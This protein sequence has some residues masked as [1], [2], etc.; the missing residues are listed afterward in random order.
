MATNAVMVRSGTQ[1]QKG[2]F[3]PQ[4]GLLYGIGGL[5]EAALEKIRWPDC[6]RLSMLREPCAWALLL[7]YRR[8]HQRYSMPELLPSGHANGRHT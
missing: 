4:F 8:R 5:F 1:F 2:I 3:F 7:F 6:F